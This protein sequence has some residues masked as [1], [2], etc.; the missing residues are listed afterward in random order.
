MV[1]LVHLNQ[2]IHFN[3]QARPWARIPAGGKCLHVN[4][5]FIFFECRPA[6]FG[7]RGQFSAMTN[8]L[9]PAFEIPFSR[10]VSKLLLNQILS[11]RHS[12]LSFVFE[13]LNLG[14]TVAFQGL[15]RAM[16]ARHFVQLDYMATHLGPEQICFFAGLWQLT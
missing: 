15:F 10:Q 5:V 7:L 9:I 4:W 1:K 3:A 6:L 12:S 11:S 2:V 16:R 8:L 13:S 14:L